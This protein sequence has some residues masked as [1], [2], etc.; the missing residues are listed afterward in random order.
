M[1]DVP[2][3]SLPEL[4]PVSATSFSQQQLKMSVLQ[5]FSNSQTHH[6]KLFLLITPWHQLHKKKTQFPCCSTNIDKKTCLF[7]EPLLSNSCC[8]VAYFVV[9]A[10]NPQAPA[11]ILAPR[12]SY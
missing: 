4:P 6:P 10:A 1:T 3:F 12:P 7:A 2:F 8:S 11:S 5:L 9:I